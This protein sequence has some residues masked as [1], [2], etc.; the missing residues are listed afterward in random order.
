M[1]RESVCT[2]V[3]SRPGVMQASLRA[4]LAGLAGVEVVGSAGDGLSALN[5]VRER[6]PDLLVVDCS[7]LEEETCALLR[8][9]KAE[10]PR[11]RCLALTRTGRQRDRAAAAGAD[12]V[13]PRD[14]PIRELRAAVTREGS[15]EA[16]RIQRPAEEAQR[17]TEGTRAELG[18]TLVSL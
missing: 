4:T 1:P 18:G 11:V 5:L 14:G 7:L 8:Q 6:P 2:V 13:L 3:A 17:D 12:V 15:D 16:N 9:V 10:W